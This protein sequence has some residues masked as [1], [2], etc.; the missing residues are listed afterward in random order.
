MSQKRRRK[1]RSALVRASRV[2]GWRETSVANRTHSRKN[3]RGKKE[4][5]Q[6]WRELSER[7]EVGRP[8]VR[9]APNISGSMSIHCGPLQRAHCGKG[10]AVPERCS[11]IL[12]PRFGALNLLSTDG[13]DTG[14]WFMNETSRSTRANNVLS[15]QVARKRARQSKGGSNGD[16][17]SNQRLL[18]RLKAENE[19][20]RGVVVDLMLQLQALCDALGHPQSEIRPNRRRR[21]PGRRQ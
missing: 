19:Q 10:R 15:L 6:S 20:L 2:S 21:P 3:P 13:R 5:G 11:S 17:G 9:G 12:V 14:W 7:M 8:N 18:E 1:A 4:R 16:K